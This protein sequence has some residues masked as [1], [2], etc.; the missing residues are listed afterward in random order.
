MDHNSS[1]PFCF[2]IARVSIFW[3]LEKNGKT[4]IKNRYI[5][6]SVLQTK[7]NKF[8][9]NCFSLLCDSLFIEETVIQILQFIDCL[10][11]LSLNKN[12]SMVFDGVLLFDQTTE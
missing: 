3:E 12:I 5:N 10:P 2:F 9:R 1:S 11:K 8:P 7:G 4:S 6:L